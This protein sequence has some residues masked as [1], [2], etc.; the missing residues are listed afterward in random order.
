MIFFG[1]KRSKVQTQEASSACYK[2]FHKNNDKILFKV[3]QTMNIGFDLDKIFI[4]YPPFVPDWLIDKLYKK[5]ANGELSYRMPSK[6]E[7]ILRLVSHYS[8]F[9][10]PIKENIEIIKKLYR[11][12]NKHYLISSR[13]NFLKNKTEVLIKKHQLD[14]FFDGLFFNF[15]NEQPHL[16]KN[17]VIKKLKIGLYVDDD[18]QLLQ[19]LSA[20]NSKVKFFWLN[21]NETRK[22]ENNLFAIR[23]LSEM[24]A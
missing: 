16:F 1:K 11:N 13:F 15:K 7:Q 3:K 17:N 6:A 21:N 5:G 10:P 19:Y 9:R 22:L 24:F 8:I 4:D 18:L 14:K 12:N 2:N 20:K 23:K